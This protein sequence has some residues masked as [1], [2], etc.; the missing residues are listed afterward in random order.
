METYQLLAKERIASIREIQKSPSKSLF[1]LTRVMRGS[2][3]LGF[4]FSV[5]EFE[6]L[7][8]DLEAAS[9]KSLR[10]RVRLARKGVKTRDLI[11]ISNLAE[12]YGERLAGRGY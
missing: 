2:K 8:E 12:E 6:E 5:Q 9:S 4:F 3:T 10:Q 11:S 1:G 7:L